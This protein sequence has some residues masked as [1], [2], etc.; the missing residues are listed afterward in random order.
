MEVCE[1]IKHLTEQYEEM[2]GWSD[3]ML[4]ACAQ[5]IKSL[6]AI[7]CRIG[8]SIEETAR[9]FGV[10]TRT[11]RRRVQEGKLPKP[12]RQGHKEITFY[13]DE[14]DEYEKKYSGEKIL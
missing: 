7:K 13:T 12:H 1:E 5:T 6:I 4:Y 3:D 10:S 2:C 14:I 9:Y 8:L 11:I